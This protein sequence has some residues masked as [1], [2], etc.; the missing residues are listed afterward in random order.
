VDV[1]LRCSLVE[2]DTRV[3]ALDVRYPVLDVPS[4]LPQ[5]SAP[6]DPVLELRHATCRAADGAAP[7]GLSLSFPPASVHLLTGE[8]GSGRNELLR[9]LGLLEPPE[10]GEVLFEGRLTSALT[11]LERDEIRSQRC[12]FLFAAPFL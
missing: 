5:M 2:C 4:A 10:T 12:G 11:A 3:S 1:P 9:M 7:R 6:P 8:A